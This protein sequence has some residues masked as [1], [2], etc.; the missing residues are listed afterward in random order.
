MFGS[1]GASSSSLTALLLVAPLLG[2]CGVDTASNSENATARAPSTNWNRDIQSTALEVDLASRSAT[3]VIAVDAAS[4]TG[5]SFEVGDLEIEQ[6]VGSDGPLKFRVQDGTLDVGLPARQPAE[7]TVHY[8]FHEHQKLEGLTKAG[9]TF[10]WPYF[11]GNLF[12]CKSDPSDGLRFELALDGVPDGKAA[13]F[14]T[15][16][17]DQ[18][19]SYM[20]AWAVGDYTRIDLGTT[21]HGRA[22]SVHH[23][24]GEAQIASA[25]T[26]NQWLEDTYGEYMFGNEV[27]S[28]SAAWGDGAFGGM[29]HHPFWHVSSG[30]MGDEET[31][32]HEAAH[33]WFGNGVRLAC[34]E[35]LTL[36]E[37]TTSYLAARSLEAVKGEAAGNAVWQDFEYQLDSVISRD[38]KIAWPETCGAIDVYHDL[39]N[40]VPYMKG[41]FFYR[42]VEQQVG[43]DAI[44]QVIAAFYAEYKGEAATMQDM[45]DVIERETGFDPSALAEGWLRSMGRPD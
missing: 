3:A 2:A 12:P 22:V 26:A 4:R 9:V 31:H 1:R 8:R 39:W 45:L 41:A 27:G 44:D 38:D 43:R 40:S 42:A 16:V 30:S 35:D 37:G 18:A 34:W 13:V 15:Q 21:A 14:P 7:L 6:V 28:V 20:L 33:G 23:L 19:P 24:P 17:P 11:C 36:S 10:S 25:G 5:A 32:A 29:E